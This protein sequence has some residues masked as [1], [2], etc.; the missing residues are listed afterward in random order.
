MNLRRQLLAGILGTALA[1]AGAGCGSST[2]GPSDALVNGTWIGTSP[3]RGSTFTLIITQNGSTLTGT[4][5]T[6]SAGTGTISGTKSGTAIA[7]NLNGTGGSCSL[8]YTGTLQTSLTSIN[9][10]VVPI[11]C[12]SNT[13]GTLNL[14]KS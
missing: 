10:T 14:T 11:N 7:V 6:N 5:S 8:T 1:L 2:T 9:G 12:N 3:E 4:W 13:I